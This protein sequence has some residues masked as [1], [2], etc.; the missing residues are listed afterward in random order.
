MKG[1]FGR[2]WEGARIQQVTNGPVVFDGKRGAPVGRI[3]R[4]VIIVVIGRVVVAALGRTI[5]HGNGCF[6]RGPFDLV[7]G[8]LCSDAELRRILKPE[9]WAI[10]A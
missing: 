8:A 1:Q 7:A 10:G 6:E 4:V 3:G 9:Q 2:D 5:I